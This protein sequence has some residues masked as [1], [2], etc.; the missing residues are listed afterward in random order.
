[1]AKIRV[2]EGLTIESLVK[3]LINTP[4]KRIV[5][6]VSENA[7]LLNNDINLRLLKFY[8]EEEEKEIVVHSDDPGLI[9][10]AHQLGFSTVM[11]KRLAPSDN[12]IKPEADYQGAEI[13]IAASPETDAE[14][15][16]GAAWNQWRGGLQLAT[17]I[18][19]FS[20]SL[21]GWWLLQ[22][23]A[24]VI[25]YPKE[26]TL[27]FSADVQIGAAFNAQEIPDGRVPAKIL[28]KENQIKVQTVTT[29]SKI[30]GVT[31]AVGRVTLVNSTGQPV[32]LPK[33]S[34]V[35]GKAGTRFLTD[36]DVLVPKRHTKYQDGIAVGEEYGRAEVNITAD[37][38]GTVGNQPS[39][40]I[41]ILSGKY[42][43]FLRVINS[44][45]T[46]NGS[47]KKVAVVALNDVK[48][49]ELEAKRQMQL[50]GADE[51]SA[52]TG[53]EYLYLSQL[54][55]S[56]IIRVVNAPDI[57]EESE[58]L[59]TTL[60]YRTSVL[61][62][63]TDDI[64]KYLVHKF[65]ASIPTGFQAKSERV[66][67]VAVKPDEIT[68]GK[69]VLALTGRGLI[70]GVLKP[71]NIKEL[72]KGKTTDEATSLLTR[73]NEVGRF[74]IDLKNGAAKLPRYSFQMKVVLPAGGEK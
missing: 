30:V 69:A 33:G 57:G 36:R 55:D 40:S 24:V 53:K 28:E 38:K 72:I 23:R 50:V 42:Q 58:L 14:T 65:K 3:E 12:R 71:D 64:F 66:E 59:E 29:G 18:S 17:I 15:P 68:E 21:A 26:Q 10:L 16:T 62:T 32:V 67:L 74:K 5:L 37:E 44:S 41:T 22:P 39:K 1:M 7:T 70:N 51:I 34:V 43:R 56:E 61:T 25:V 48:K 8:A 46:R 49:G 2:E 11:D 47:N 4:G 63:L 13:E 45:P 35:I 52:L 31:P 19:M 6:E 9:G 54:V 20:L 73:Q 27:T 60:D